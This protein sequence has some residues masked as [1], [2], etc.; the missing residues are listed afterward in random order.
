MV[1]LKINNV[2]IDVERGTTILNAALS[3]G[4]YI[5]ALCSHPNLS[6]AKGLKGT[7]RI[8]RKSEIIGKEYEYE[9]C[10]LCIVEVNGELLTAC[11][12]I[13]SDG[14]DIYTNKSNVISERRKNLAKILSKH[15]H[16]CLTCAQKEGCP[17]EPCSENVPKNER[18]CSKLGNCELEKIVEY[19]GFPLETQRYIPRNLEVINDIPLFNIDYNLCIGCLRCVR[20]CN[21]LVGAKAIGFTY[22]DEILVGFVSKEQC[23]F[24]CTCVEVCPTGALL[25]K[26]PL[27]KDELLPCK[28]NC[29]ADID[30]PG[31]IHAISEGKFEIAYKIVKEKVLFPSMIGRVCFHPCENH[32]RRREVNEPIAICSLKRFL[33]DNFNSEKLAPKYSNDKA[34]EFSHRSNSSLFHRNPSYPLYYDEKKIAV[35]GSGPAGLACAYYLA[36]KGY[37]VSIFEEQ[38]ELGGM[39]RYGIPSYRLPKEILKRSI[40]EIIEGIEVITSKR[41]NDIS[42]IKEKYDAIFIACGLQKS[43]RLMGIEDNVILGLEFLKKVNNGE[44]IEVGKKVIVIGGGNVAIDVSLTALRLCAEEV[45]VVCLEKREEMPAFDYE[46]REAIDEGINIY[47]ALGPK[48]VIFENGIIK[49]VEF[50]KCTSVFDEKGRFAP[51]FDENIKKTIY[52]DQVILAI[53]QSLESSFLNNI[54]LSNGFIKVNERMETNEKGIFAGGDAIG[55]KQSVIDALVSGKRAAIEIDKYL[56]GDGN[57]DETPKK[58]EFHLCNVSEGFAGMKREKINKIDLGKRRKSFEEVELGY[59]ESSAINEA[60]RCLYCD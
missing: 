29:P 54:S 51:T 11:N 42:S 40:E 60:K 35:I 44:K 7:E 58:F 43:K 28:K 32:C 45:N 6:N 5:P 30:I 18:C 8:Y 46:V 23:R 1:S 27:S 48:K 37:K 55:N 21:E 12:T 17:R 24:C 49:G 19:I 3:A 9:G 41:I 34:S 59:N 10:K 36:K 31:Y 15:P 33:G 56:G 38:K 14:M 20:A 2:S 53:G 47:N 39:L 22:R 26:K 52:G 16:A 50:V 57:I 25:D 4:I 13:V